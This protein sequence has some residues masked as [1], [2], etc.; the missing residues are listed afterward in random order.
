MP[1]TLSGTTGISL[2]S[3]A[4]PAFS[5]YLS[6]N[7]SIS[8]GVWTKIT[9]Q[10][11]EFDTNG[12]YDNATNYR[13]Q[14]TV[15]G[16]YQISGAFVTTSTSGTSM[17]I[18]IYKNGSIFKAGTY[19][20]SWGEGGNISALVYLNG[21]TDYVELYCI[22]PGSARTLDGTSVAGTYFQ[23]AMVRSA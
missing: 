2:P 18:A 1:M 5:A 11:E 16:Y 20:I 9:C 19:N 6:A 14:P 23:G 21:S 15:A 8:A 3:A 13:F 10:T 4:A 22:M 17:R 7:Q 12:N